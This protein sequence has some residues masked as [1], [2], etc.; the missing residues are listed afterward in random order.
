MVEKSSDKAGKT[1]EEK[2]VE[3]VSTTEKVD[4]DGTEQSTEQFVD[5]AGSSRER[6]VKADPTKSNIP[7]NPDKEDV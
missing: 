6:H 7:I 2:K 1:S 5:Y 3:L 4:A